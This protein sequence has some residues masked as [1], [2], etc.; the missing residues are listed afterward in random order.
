[1]MP[2]PIAEK[3]G[4]GLRWD[5]TSLFGDEFTVMVISS[6]PSLLN[7]DH[8]SSG[9]PF[10]ASLKPLQ[11]SVSSL[12]VWYTHACIMIRWSSKCMQDHR[13]FLMLQTC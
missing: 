6:A 8:P 1:M 7:K 2:P 13:S 9:N 10:T 12:E 4:D 3:S 5:P 11:S